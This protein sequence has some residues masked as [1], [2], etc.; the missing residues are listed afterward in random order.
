MDEMNEKQRRFAEE[1]LVDGSISAAARR[2]GYS[3]CH[4]VQ[5][6]KKE[7]MRSYIEQRKKQMA[8]QADA[9]C[10]EVIRELSTIAFANIADYMKVVNE[11][12]EARV[13]ALPT[14]EIPPE[15]MRAVAQIKQG[16][17]GVEIKLCDKMRALN[18]LGLHTGAFDLQEGK[19]DE[20]GGL[21]EA[22]REA[23]QGAW[24]D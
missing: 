21:A 4:A 9:D 15:K 22:L 10:S 13:V 19:S 11:E 7:E 8:A 5:L 16:T 20:D 23:A 2:S 6:M 3:K 14:E 12:G 1:Y 17:K 24:E 18:L